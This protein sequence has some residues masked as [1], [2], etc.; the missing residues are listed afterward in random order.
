M[1]PDVARFLA[2]LEKTQY[3]DERHWTAY[4]RRLLDRLLRHARAE[5]GLYPDRLA[6]VFRTDD[7]I[8]WDRWG[9]IPILTRA[10]AQAHTEELT[11]R[12]LPPAAGRAKPAETSGSTGESWEFRE[13]EIHGHAIACANARFFGWHGLSPDLTAA[14]LSTGHPD[15]TWPEGKELGGWRQDVEGTRAMTLSLRTPH[16]RQREWLARL[17]PDLVISFPSNLLAIA[18]IAE[19]S[20]AASSVLPPMKVVTY[21]ETLTGEA[22]RAI[23]SGFGSDPIDFYGSAEAGFVAGM[24]PHSGT[25]HV[26]SDLLLLELVDDDGQTVAA[27][28]EGRVVVTP[29]YGYATPLIRY[30]L[31]DR[32]IM[33]RE[34]CGC[35]RT[36]PSINRILG[37][38]RNVFRFS[39]GTSVWPS[40]LSEDV[41]P[42]V[43]HRRFQVVQTAPDRIEYRYTPSGEDR[44]VDVEGLTRLFRQRLHP[45]LTVT[46]VRVDEITT[47]AKREDYICAFQ[48]GL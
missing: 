27:G 16:E 42:F 10:E 28:E 38:T 17:R 5:T 19:I 14:V 11:A 34:P 36:L 7:T 25:Y 8:D 23:R 31:G 33:A 35:G 18:E 15:A 48:S 13:T 30:D 12:N 3:L 22:K 44:P 39:D 46:P 4:Q 41:Q 26:T 40:V 9:D 29:F 6:S 21:G 2:S 37:R 45:S 32:A 24:C 20:E 1:N 47:S 43:P